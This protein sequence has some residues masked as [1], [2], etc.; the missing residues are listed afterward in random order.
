MEFRLAALAGFVFVGLGV[1]A[2]FPTRERGA[3]RSRAGA[4]VRPESARP[5][6][7][8]SPDERLATPGPCAG[9]RPLATTSSGS[10]P[11]GF[12]L[13]DARWVRVAVRLPEGLPPDDRPVLLAASKKHGELSHLTRVRIASETRTARR[14]EDTI[15]RYIA[16]T[17]RPAV[18]EVESVPFP[19]RAENALVLL[20]SRYLYHA[21]AMLDL[22]SQAALVLEP[23]LGGYVAGRCTLPREARGR[24]IDLGDV[25]IELDNGFGD[26]R[27]TECDGNGRFELWGLAPGV[28]YALVAHANGL[29]SWWT[30]VKVEPGQRA[31]L[32]IPFEPGGI[33]RGVVLD[34]AGQPVK[35]ARVSAEDS[36][37]RR[38]PQVAS[39]EQ[40]CF[41]LIGVRKGDAKLTATSRLGRARLEL[42][43]RNG[44]ITRGLRLELVPQA[45]RGRVAYCR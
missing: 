24:G 11:P 19:G 15:A 32:A 10:T 17:S 12:A 1:L 45:A 37:G 38:S 39:D 31:A 14:P 5:P 36:L 40:G 34:P 33:V 25:T 16:W 44:R 30:S 26:P 7:S 2:H 20:R 13:E 43:V 41:E 22:R 3:G 23:V 6:A 42:S 18:A 9:R 35:G 28:S 8:P 29:P 4:E 21:P 27:R